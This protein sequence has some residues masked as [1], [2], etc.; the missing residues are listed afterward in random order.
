[1]Q[2]YVKF[3]TLPN[4]LT[5]VN[6]LILDYPKLSSRYKQRKAALWRPFTLIDYMY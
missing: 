5:L 2:R 4:Y 3:W 6:N 1:M